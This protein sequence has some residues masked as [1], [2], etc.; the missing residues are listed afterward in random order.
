[1]AKAARPVHAG[2]V[3]VGSS[4]GGTAGEILRGPGR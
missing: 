3:N 4:S 1:M 2:K